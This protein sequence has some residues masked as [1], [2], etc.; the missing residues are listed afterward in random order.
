MFRDYLSEKSESIHFLYDRKHKLL[1][2]RNA[3]VTIRQRCKISQM[4]GGFE[5]LGRKETNC[6]SLE[7]DTTANSKIRPFK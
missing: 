1:F 2:C 5:R 7:G 4:C 3:K 6:D